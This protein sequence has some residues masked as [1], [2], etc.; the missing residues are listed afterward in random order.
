MVESFKRYY[1]NS[2]LDSQRQEAYNLFLGNYIFTQGQPM[3]WDLTTDYYLHHVDPR[4]WFDRQCRDYIQWFTPSFLEPRALPHSSEPPTELIKKGVDRFDDYWLEYYR[5]LAISSFL[6][7]YSFML[8]SP[9]RYLPDKSLQS[10]DYDFSPFRPRKSPHDSDSPDKKPPRKG[11]TIVDPS[12]DTDTRGPSLSI[13]ARRN[14]ARL[15]ANHRLGHQNSPI[16]SSI[17]RDPHFETAL[18]PATSPTLSSSSVFKP[19]DKSLMP[20][21]TLDQFHSNSLNPSVT[22][23]EAA[24][25]AEYISHPLNLPLVVSAETPTASDPIAL[26][27]VEY[28]GLAE[29]DGG[30]WDVGDEEV[31][32]FEEFLTVAENPLD[33]GEE[34]GGKKRYKA[35]RQWLKGKSLFKQSKV[36][37]EYQGH[38]R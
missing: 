34:D 6:K 38:G 7:I 4:G 30:R 13:A 17:L 28:L 25:Y 21:W 9:A 12:S 23:A 10:R 31:G 27:F 8:N 18:P 37:P 16:K 20:Q 3:L 36:D 15:A 24:E 14:Q 1:H 26:D 22:A 29:G 35:Y 5:P 33:V 32:V 2:F 19:P 11:V